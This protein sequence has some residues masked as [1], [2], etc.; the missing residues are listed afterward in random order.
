[1]IQSVT[2]RWNSSYSMAE[3]FIYLATHVTTTIGQLKTD[4]PTAVTDLE[5]N[6]MSDCLPLLEKF[7]E[8]TEIMSGDKYVTSGQSIS[9]LRNLKRSL[10][11]SAP[12]STAAN[13]LKK[14]L[15]LQLESRMDNLNNN[16]ILLKACLLD[17][18]YK[19]KYIS[20]PITKERIISE[21]A[22]EMRLTPP[23]QI[24]IVVYF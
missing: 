15:L 10:T 18:R 24:S 23:I 20:D 22:R 16:D 4:P 9:V 5:L 13:N 3:R 21:V 1:M 6:M 11:N 12:L 7:L 2:T 14:H 17:P 8:A 19:D